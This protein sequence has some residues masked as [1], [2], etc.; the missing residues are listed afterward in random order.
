ML[1]LEEHHHHRLRLGRQNVFKIQFHLIFVEG[2]VIQAF[3]T[4]SLISL[5]Y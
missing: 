4:L 1:G 3:L 5:F 2:G